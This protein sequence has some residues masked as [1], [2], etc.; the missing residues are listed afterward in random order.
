MYSKILNVEGR[1][2]LVFFARQDVEV[3]QELTYNYRWGHPEGCGGEQVWVL[4]VCCAAWQAG[5]PVC[6]APRGG[7]G[8]AGPGGAFRQDS[9]MYGRCSD[10]HIM[11]AC[12]FAV[13][14]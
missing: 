7:T 6:L 14:I 10:A 9:S 1:Q 13:Q 3:G 4:A 8:V 5:R 2:R 11:A 12:M